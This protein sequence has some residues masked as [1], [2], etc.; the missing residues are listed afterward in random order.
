MSAKRKATVAPA[1]ADRIVGEGEVAVAEI[2]ANPANWRAHSQEQREAMREI[3]AKVGWISRVIVN[4]RTGLL[5]DG[6]MRVEEAA[7]IGAKTVPVE[8]V[9]LSVEEERAVLAVF[10]PIAAMAG[11]DRD[12]LRA[13]LGDLTG[14]TEGLSKL[15]DDL[16]SKVADEV[17]EERPEVEFT[18][19][20]L[21]SHNYVVLYFDN[22]VD[23]L[24][25]Q[26]LY[27]LPERKS[28]RSDGKFQQVGMGR[29]VKGIEFIRK[30]TGARGG[31][32]REGSSGNDAAPEARPRASKKK[33]KR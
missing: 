16:R 32:S 23:W 6:H 11:I 31:N 30:I 8:F 22:D 14:D 5:I 13:V 28:L 15:I 26:S 19:E 27:P 29:V 24:H 20:L 3:F 9:D 18:E 17:P 33:G 10:D 12:R 2:R 25:L 21:E 1:I 7:R 4:R